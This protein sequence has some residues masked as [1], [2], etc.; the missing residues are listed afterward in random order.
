MSSVR[1]DQ[2][3]RQVWRG[4]VC[5]ND[6]NNLVRQRESKALAARKLLQQLGLAA[7]G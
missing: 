1:C 2:Q 7:Q 3:P 6:V 4:L 5:S